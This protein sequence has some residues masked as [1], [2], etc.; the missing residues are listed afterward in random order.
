M[1]VARTFFPTFDTDTHK[2]NVI[3]NQVLYQNNTILLETTEHKYKYFLSFRFE[4]QQVHFRIQL[5]LHVGFNFSQYSDSYCSTPYCTFITKTRLKSAQKNGKIFFMSQ[6]YT[7]ILSD[8]SPTKIHVKLRENSCKRLFS[9]FE[10]TASRN[11]W[12]FIVRQIKYSVEWA[13][14]SSFI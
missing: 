4:K 8:P 9:C 5:K 12:L 2:E 1:P 7:I 11:V 6:I 3:C 10:S 13:A 14:Q